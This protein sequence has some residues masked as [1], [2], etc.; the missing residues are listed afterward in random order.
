MLGLTVQEINDAVD[1]L[2]SIGLIETLNYM[3]NARPMNS[4]S[5]NLLMPC[6]FT[7]EN[8]WLAMI[9]RLTLRRSLLLLL[10][11]NPS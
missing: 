3:E 4:G 11:N 8:S 7:F 1:E 10:P 9:Q 6:L 5:F 2:E